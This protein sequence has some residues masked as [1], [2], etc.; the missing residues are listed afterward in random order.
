VKLD[1]RVFV[2]TR[3]NQ[4]QRVVIDAVNLNRTT[5]VEVR[6]V[7]IDWDSKR[8]AVPSAFWDQSNRVEPLARFQATLAI[9][10]LE[11]LGFNLPAEAVAVVAIV[12]GKEFKS[13][14]K[15]LAKLTMP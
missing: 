12:F 7:Y 13:K 14:P 10:E 2:G 4:A 1:V 9:P 5:A 15:R 11:G 6:S 8:I 3:P